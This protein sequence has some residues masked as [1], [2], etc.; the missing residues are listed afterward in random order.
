MNCNRFLILFLF[1]LFSFQ[2]L[3]YGQNISEYVLEIGE[4]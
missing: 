2:L 1:M 3:T 4:K